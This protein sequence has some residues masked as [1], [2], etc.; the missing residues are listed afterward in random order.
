MVAI[1]RYNPL[2]KGVLRELKCEGKT[3]LGEDGYGA[4]HRAAVCQKD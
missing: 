4:S 2:L 3:R 1:E